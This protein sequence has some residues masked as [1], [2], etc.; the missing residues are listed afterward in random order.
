M[1]PTVSKKQ[2]MD[3]HIVSNCAILNAIGNQRDLVEHC[4][5]Y[6]FLQE[7]DPFDT[8]NGGD[9]FEK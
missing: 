6:H 4:D 8:G 3:E 1:Q 7:W 5:R 2:P 9:H